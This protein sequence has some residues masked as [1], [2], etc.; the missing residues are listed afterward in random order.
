MISKEVFIGRA[1]KTIEAIKEFDKYFNGIEN[2]FGGC[3]L[4]RVWK[5][6]IFDEMISNLSA[7]MGIESENDDLVTFPFTDYRG[8][9]YFPYGQKA[10]TCW[11]ANNNEVE[12]DSWEEFYNYVKDFMT[13][14]SD[15]VE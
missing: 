2:A 14:E 4:E 15:L 3:V 11:N 9:D 5:L 8:T 10:I 7:A 13:C 6:K 1:K 12:I